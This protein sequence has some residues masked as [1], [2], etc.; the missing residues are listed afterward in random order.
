MGK[1]GNKSRKSVMNGVDSAVRSARPTDHSTKAL[2]PTEE[3]VVKKKQLGI[4]PWAIE[5]NFIQKLLLS[6]WLY[7]PHFCSNFQNLKSWS[8]HALMPNEY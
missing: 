5:D 6:F 2:E 8:T 4:A 3:Y 1:C 7:T